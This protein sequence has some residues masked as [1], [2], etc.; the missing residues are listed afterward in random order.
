[1]NTSTWPDHYDLNDTPD[2]QKRFQKLITD[3]LAALKD[4]DEQRKKWVKDNLPSDYKLTYLF[5]DHTLRVAE[6]VKHTLLY[7]GLSE[8]VAN[9]MYDA[10]LLHDCGKSQLPL[11]LWDMVD[12]PEDHIKSERRRHTEIGAAIIEDQLSD[13]DHPHKDLILDI[14]RYHHEQMDGQGHAGIKGDKLS[15]PVRLACIVES[16]DGYSIARPHFGDRDVSVPGVLARMR[17]EKGAKLYDM[18]LFE[19][20]AQMK[21]SRYKEASNG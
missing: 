16:F 20:F 6:D 1:M 3:Q 14:I 15:K 10:M 4:L 17:D 8:R 9:H 21:I 7:M 18:E 19:T 12:K 2:I 13:I 5:H 11:H